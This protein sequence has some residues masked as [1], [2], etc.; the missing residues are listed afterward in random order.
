MLDTDGDGLI[1]YKEI[2][3]HLFHHNEAQGSSYNSFKVI[4]PFIS[5]ELSDNFIS[6]QMQAIAEQSRLHY[7]ERKASNEQLELVQEVSEEI[8][9]LESVEE[10]PK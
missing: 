4:A 9:D 3:R 1:S 8:P 5:C 7:R 2:E 10:G 6:M